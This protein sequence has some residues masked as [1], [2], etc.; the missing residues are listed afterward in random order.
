MGFDWREYLN[1][2][3]FLR[4]Q[5]GPGFG[6]EATSRCAVSRAYY[7]AFC[8]ARNHERDEGKFIPEYGYQDH[9]LL[10]KY[11]R[12]RDTEVAEWLDDLRRWRNKCDYQDRVPGLE[13]LAKSAIELAGRLLRRLT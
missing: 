1:L 6:G 12:S 10:R 11:F 4:G 3:L 13:R 2:S 5:E 7:S 9:A 8:H